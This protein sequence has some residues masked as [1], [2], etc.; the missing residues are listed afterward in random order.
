MND[1]PF[2]V[3]YWG[4]RGGGARLAR[5]TIFEIMLTSDYRVYTSVKSHLISDLQAQFPGRLVNHDPRIPNSKFQILFN[6]KAR[7]RTIRRFE[8]FAH[9]FNIMRIVVCMSHPW[10]VSISRK[11]SRSIKVF[12]VIHDLKPHKGDIWP[13]RFTI[14]RLIR[15]KNLI[16]LSNYISN[17][18]SSTPHII[19]SLARYRPTS[20]P[21]WSNDLP[22]IFSPYLLIAG[23]GK[24]YQSMPAAL[25]VA[26]KVPDLNIV[27]T[28]RVHKKYRTSTRI[29]SINRWLTDSELEFLI[30]NASVVLCLYEEASQS[31]LVEQAKYWGVPIVVTN[32]GALVEQ[33]EGRINCHIV[34]TSDPEETLQ[35]I[36]S[37]L[38]AHKLPLNFEPLPT[39]HLTLLKTITS[40]A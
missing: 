25:E 37:C 14:S 27:T 2:L 3:H 10:D 8:K 11:L 5:E 29:K 30:S 23:R 31:G 19:G 32:K 35:A 18:L 28:V 34:E 6:Y 36:K 39:L 40:P 21:S 7:L 15:E 22:E 20:A 13:T 16:V 12:R 24:R 38:N 9:E 4:S 17:L 1:Y 33:V 26:L